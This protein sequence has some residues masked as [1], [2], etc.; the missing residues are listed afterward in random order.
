[1]DLRYHLLDVFTD[2]PFGGNQLAVFPGAP[3]LATDLMQR[4]A[5][6]LNLSETVFVQPA[7]DS[8]AT[9]ALRIFTPGM[10]LP[11]AG[12]PTLGTAHLLVE[13]GMV[14]GDQALGGFALEEKV[15]CIPVRVERRADGLLFA[16][17][18]AAAAPETQGA[19]PS[20]RELAA[21]LGIDERDVAAE[22][23][24]LHGDAPQAVSMGVPFLLIPV[25]DRAA[26]GRASVDL[27]A[28]R[29]LLVTAWAPHLYVF[30]RDAEG[31]GVDLRA[32]MFAPAMGISEDPATGAAAAALSAYLAWRAPERD[33]TLRWIVEQGIEMG[34]PSR[35]H[36][37]AV[38]QEGQLRSVRIGGTS[39]R[40]GEGLL[41]L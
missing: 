36:L 1:V 35:L 5:R 18:T 31:P 20:R 27:T 40:V 9:H 14:T 29:R 2:A 12:H 7:R 33:A 16:E 30:C 11:F 10:E 19:A 28:W 15:G 26:L 13:L 25:R 23:D 39:V 38:K 4:V 37:T 34:R 22:G 41:R 32:R 24:S 3:T 8:G 6:E 17:L 21:L